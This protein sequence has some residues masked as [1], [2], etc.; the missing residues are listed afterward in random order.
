MRP[1]VSRAHGLRRGPSHY[2]FP[3]NRLRISSIALPVITHSLSGIDRLSDR[4]HP[5]SIA[6][7]DARSILSLSDK[8]LRFPH[9]A[10]SL[11]PS[12]S[13]LSELVPRPF[14]L[15][16][17]RT[18]CGSRAHLHRACARPLLPCATRAARLLRLKSRRSPPGSHRSPSLRYSARRLALSL[19]LS[20]PCSRSWRTVAAVL[21]APPFA[22]SRS[23]PSCVLQLVLRVRHGT[24]AP[25]PFLSS[26]RSI[27]HLGATA[28]PRLL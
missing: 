20:S 1:P 7:L 3:C 6:S 22:R 2:D 17:E 11:V 13:L 25:P 5:S 26:T 18:T 27:P 9:A 28:P 10:L 24:H 14:F 4:R 15:Q 19:T 23:R 8:P 12:R 21:V 16:H